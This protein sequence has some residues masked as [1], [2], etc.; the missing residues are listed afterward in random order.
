MAAASARTR[1]TW[2][3][4]PPARPS[5][6][7]R[8]PAPSRPPARPSTCPAIVAKRR[9]LQGRRRRRDLVRERQ[10]RLR[11]GRLGARPE[12][13][14]QGAHAGRRQRRLRQGHRP[15]AGPHR[16]AAWACAATRYSMLVKDGKVASLNVEA[17]GKFEVSDAAYLAGPGA[18]AEPTGPAKASDLEVVRARRSGCDSRAGS[19]RSPDPRRARA[20]LPCRP[21]CPAARRHS[22]RCARRRAIA[23]ASWRPRP[24]PRNAVAHVQPLHLR[25]IRVVGRVQRPQR[26]AAA[27]GDRARACSMCAVGR[28]LSAA[29]TSATSS[30][31]R[32]SA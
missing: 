32:G 9:R 14:R 21:A 17:P 4:P 25:G 18:G 29:S 11:D 28:V 27:T 8:C 16:H 13:R 15:D 31:P 19:P 23:S 7:S 22:R 6:C 10:R 3:R 20:R 30:A 1:S 2:P 26:A 12:D 24:R 5:R